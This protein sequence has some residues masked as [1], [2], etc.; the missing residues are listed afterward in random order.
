M[1]QKINQCVLMQPKH[2]ISSVKENVPSLAAIMSPLTVDLRNLKPPKNYQPRPLGDDYFFSSGC[3]SHFPLLHACIWLCSSKLMAVRWALRIAGWLAVGKRNSVSLVAGH[4]QHGPLPPA[5][6][7]P[8]SL[9]WAWRA[10]LMRR[11]RWTRRCRASV[12]AGS[13]PSCSC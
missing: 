9:R 8:L 3:F 7:F 1:L 4:N 13:R 2:V 6:A 11:T 12:S 10:A 5:A